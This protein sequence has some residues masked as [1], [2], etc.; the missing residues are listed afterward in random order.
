MPWK[1]S[2]KMMTNKMELSD[3]YTLKP[4]D[5]VHRF[6]NSTKMGVVTDVDRQPDCVF[7]T[8][9]NDP[10]PYRAGYSQGVRV[11]REAFFWQEEKDEGKT[12][13]DSEKNDSAETGTPNTEG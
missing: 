1:I 11:T 8:L 2:K 7:V 13:K 6:S 12:K 9:N 3:A 4:G 10:K 5:Y